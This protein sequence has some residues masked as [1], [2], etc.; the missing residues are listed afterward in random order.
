MP[1]ICSEDIRRNTDT[2]LRKRTQEEE[3]ALMWSGITN[4]LNRICHPGVKCHLR[5]DEWT[6]V[7]LHSTLHEKFVH[8]MRLWVMC[9]LSHIYLARRAY[10]WIEQFM[11]TQCDYNS[12]WISLLKNMRFS[13]LQTRIR[14]LNQLLPTTP[15][16]LQRT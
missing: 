1:N 12:V 5:I 7:H 8:W 16:Q 14:Q 2:V 4:T 3:T 6:E 10:Q 11:P 9:T 15:T 13:T